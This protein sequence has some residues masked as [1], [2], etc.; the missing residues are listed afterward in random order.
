[1]TAA[2]VE[3]EMLVGNQQADL[4]GHPRDVDRSAQ[5]SRQHQGHRRLIDHHRIRLVDDH[6]VAPGQNSLVIGCAEPVTQHVEPDL[7]DGDVRDVRAVRRT[8]LLMAA[9][10]ADRGNA[11]PEEGEQR[12][13]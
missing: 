10:I 2:D 12:G 4:G 11:E 13:D 9:P 8:T 6:D 7:V 3:L 5:R 1:M